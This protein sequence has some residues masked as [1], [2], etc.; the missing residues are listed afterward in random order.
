MELIPLTNEVSTLSHLCASL[1]ILA[2]ATLLSPTPASERCD[3]PAIFN[4]GDSNSDT[5]GLAA[6]FTPPNLPYGRTYFHMP[7]GRFC[8]GRLIIDFVASSFNLPFLS[9]YLDAL[10]T[11]FTNGA[12]YATAAATIRLPTRIIPNGGFSPFYL[13]VQFEQFQQFKQ[14]SRMIERRG[15]VFATLMPKE[16][17]FSQALY[18]FDIGQ[19]DLGAGFFANQSVDQVN[20]SVP[21]IIDRFVINVKNIYKEGGKSFWIHNTGPIGCLPYILTNFASAEKDTAGC[22]KAYNEVCQYFNFKL[23][24][25]VAELRQRF[26][27]ASFTYVDVY[28]VKYSLFQEPEKYGFELPL[29]SCCGYGGRYNFSIAECGD[30]T[31]LKNGT[32]I[33]VGSC[34]RPSVRV[35]WDGIHYTEAANKFVFDK[36]STGAF[37]SPPIPLEM[38][39]HRTFLD[40]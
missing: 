14:R 32:R 39:C 3:F 17:Y 31:V 13:D 4:F 18:T 27:S 16:E 26:S 36:I 21:D 6:A 5:G 20:A 7:A 10:G 12:N 40:I 23:K 38:A 25:V 28:S 33:F 1:V 30:T 24:E 22:A 8:D 35:N 34:D 11:N 15:G 19:N 37:S 2:S 29:I 9:A